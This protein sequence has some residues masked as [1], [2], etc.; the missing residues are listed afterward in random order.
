MS[1]PMSDGK[2]EVTERWT[3]TTDNEPHASTLPV[4][5]YASRQA[6]VAELVA[7]MFRSC[8]LADGMST[9]LV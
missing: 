9:I 1:Q 6:Q 8:K 2:N 3:Y 5:R 7:C 4:L